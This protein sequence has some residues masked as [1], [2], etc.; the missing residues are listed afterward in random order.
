[1]VCARSAAS[2]VLSPARLAIAAFCAG[3]PKLLSHLQHAIEPRVH[4][5]PTGD[6]L[7]E[8]SFFSL[9]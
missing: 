1:M 6:R 8:D 4:I 9:P 7:A 5:R 3:Q 2:L